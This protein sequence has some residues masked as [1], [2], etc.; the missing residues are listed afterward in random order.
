MSATSKRVR[1]ETEK[2]LGKEVQQQRDLE[3][4]TQPGGSEFN[5]LEV[6]NSRA[7]VRTF[8]PQLIERNLLDSLLEA[9]VRAPT[10]LKDECCE[11]M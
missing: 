2:A 11:Y 3:V 7:S 10:A 4:V 6:I 9:A 5:L 8:T 1:L